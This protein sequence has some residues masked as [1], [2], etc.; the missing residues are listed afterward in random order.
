VP[1][2]RLSLTA[3]VAVVEAEQ[4]LRHSPHSSSAAAARAAAAAAAATSPSIT[5]ILQDQTGEQT[6][7]RVKLTT[8]LRKVF[9]IFA[10]RKGVQ[11]SALVFVLDGDRLYYDSN[12]TAAD[13]EL[14]DDAIID[15]RLQQSGC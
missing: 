7:F 2:K 3:A 4:L 8:A 11:L 15:V 6:H 10:D 14:K 9:T 5:L 1:R 12:E 13:Y